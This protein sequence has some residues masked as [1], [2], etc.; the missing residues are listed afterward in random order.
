MLEVLD[1]KVVSVQTGAGTHEAE[2]PWIYWV[3]WVK[4]CCISRREPQSQRRKTSCDAGL[5]GHAIRLGLEDRR[6]FIGESWWMKLTGLV[7]AA[8]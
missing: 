7:T 4:A 8:K 6:A 3:R 2:V 5:S 1:E